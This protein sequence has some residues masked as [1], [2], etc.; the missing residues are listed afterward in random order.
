MNELFKH[1]PL[2]TPETKTD[3]FNKTQQYL[4]TDIC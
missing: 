4:L 3:D 2:T 1:I